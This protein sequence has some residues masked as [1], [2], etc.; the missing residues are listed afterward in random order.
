[1]ANA[2]SSHQKV[3]GFACGLLKLNKHMSFRFE[4]FNLI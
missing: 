3:L 4:K 2:Y 1:M